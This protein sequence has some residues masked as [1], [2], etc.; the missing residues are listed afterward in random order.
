MAP[1]QRL[2]LLLIF[3]PEFHHPIFAQDTT[4]TKSYAV[5][6]GITNYKDAD[7][8]PL[9]FADKDAAL[10]AAHLQSKSGGSVPVGNIKLL[11]NE[12]STIAGIY[13]ALNWLQERCTANDKAYFYFSGHGDVETEKDSSLGYLLAYNS[14]PNNYRNNAITIRDLNKV[15]NHLSAKSNSTVIL[16]TDACHSGKLAGDYYKGKELVANQLR[17]ILNNEIRLA[18][19]A[20]NEKANESED[21][22]GGRGVFSYYLLK[23]LDGM[24]DLDR[25]DTV[26]LRELNTYLDSAFAADK[27]LL[28]TSRKQHPA[29]DGNP[30]Q[31]LAIVDHAALKTVTSSASDQKSR[32]RLRSVLSM[33]KPLGRQPVDYLFGLTKT[34]AIESK[35]RFSDYMRIPKDS[36]PLMLVKEC[37]AYQQHLNNQIDSLKRLGQEADSSYFFAN[38]DTLLLAKNQLLKSKPVVNDFNE[39]FIQMV[40]GQAQD[41]INAYLEGDLEELEKREYYY[42]GNKRYTDFIDMLR[43]VLHIAPKDHYLH[44]LLAVQEA[45]ISGL[46]ARLEMVTAKNLSV[47]LKRAFMYQKKALELAPDA[48]YVHNEL[49]NLYMHR[50]KYKLAD[51]HF[52]K[53]TEIAPTWAIPWSNKVRVGLATQNLRMGVEAVRMTDSLQHNLPYNFTNAGVMMEKQGDLL[54]AESY[55]LKSVRVNRRHFFSYGK[56]GNLYISTGDYEKA[57]RFLTLA[58]MRMEGF[59]INSEFLKLPY[60][61]SS[62]PRPSKWREC[63]LFGSVELPAAKHYVQLVNALSPHSNPDSAFISLKAIAAK[64]GNMPLL[65]HYMGKM[66]FAEKRWEEAEPLLLDAIH[67]YKSDSAFLVFLEQNLR[68][69]SDAD[70]C[71]VVRLMDHHYNI[72]EDHYLL[73]SIYEHQKRADKALEQYAMITAIE[74]AGLKDQAAFRGDYVLP[75]R[76]RPLFAFWLKIKSSQNWLRARYEMPPR[77][78]GYIKLATIYEKSADYPAAEKIYL[79]QI[80]LNQ[81]VGDIRVAQPDRGPLHLGDSANTYYRIAVNRSAEAAT[82]DFYRRML[83]L[84]PRDTE[85]QEKAGMFLYNRLRLSFHKIPVRNYQA[86]YEVINAFAYPF[87]A[88]YPVAREPGDEQKTMDAEII[89]PGT[90]EKI[91]IPTPK[92]DPLKVSLASLKLAVRLSGELQT[93]PQI[94]LAIADLNSW[95]GN[96]QEAFLMYKEFISVQEPDAALRSRI[97]GYCFEINESTFAMNQLEILHRLGEAT[98]AQEI[99]LADCYARS[100]S[101][102]RA[103]V[104]LKNVKATND[105]ER[106]RVGM[107]YAKTN[108]LAGRH[109]DALGYLNAFI[110]TRTTDPAGMDKV[111]ANRYYSIARLNASLKKKDP[112]FSALNLA[113]ENGFNYG[114]VLNTDSSWKRL[115][116]SA[117]WKA[118]VQK[119]SVQLQP[120]DRVLNE[121]SDS[122]DPREILIAD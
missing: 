83:K 110:N 100:G 84:F 87:L 115:R 46:T 2:F 8:P 53:A 70:T 58:S 119:Y 109:S 59:A 112:A 103:L 32:D 6:I 122:F 106:A 33:F 98:P 13:D 102:D 105:T 72:L 60:G 51:Q 85:W 81:E 99:E 71:L 9:Q 104:L 28:R 65:N 68:P 41:R 12:N 14:P 18:A 49:G 30:D 1:W 21:W 69:A 34:G 57:D 101:T 73:A 29:L 92:Y 15:A 121:N 40:H 3:C 117:R 36:L 89:L 27:V 56:L 38:V 44:S 24:A 76:S 54:A 79:Q 25:D 61:T 47:P 64:S 39:R 120:R 17:L 37:I 19:C 16:V 80:K 114:H 20:V 67:S 75:E 31:T 42:S 35:L 86:A 5:V 62:A 94:L 7:M 50:K 23:G 43:V 113:L 111:T 88:T 4:Q 55:L 78:G 26:Q 63:D 93:K 116:Q 10:F 77:M 48:A 11:L 108:W 96:D 45:Y 66:L 107:V 22:G 91:A 97:I 82:F 74:N 118:L 90:G 95:M 52:D